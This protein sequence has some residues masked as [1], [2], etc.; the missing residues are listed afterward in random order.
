MR[1][2]TRATLLATI[3]LTTLGAGVSAE[4]SVGVSPTEPTDTTEV[5]DTT[6]V[7]GS[8]EAS[9]STKPVDT[10]DATSETDPADTSDGGPTTTSPVGSDPGDDRG[11]DRDLRYVPAGLEIPETTADDLE[12]VM[13]GEIGRIDMPIVVRNGSDETFQEVDVAGI[14]RDANGTRIAS[15]RSVSIVP[16]VLD[17]GEWGMGVAF[18]STLDV[19][20]DAVIEWVVLATPGTAP[21]GLTMREL[22]VGRPDVRTTG[23]STEIALM[24]T[25][26]KVAETVV[27]SPRAAVGCFDQT[28]R[29]LEVAS[30]F[31]FDDSLAPGESTVLEGSFYGD[32]E[33]ATYAAAAEGYDEF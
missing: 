11:P 14:V 16:S 4:A 8:T 10:P 2:H 27:E 28:G 15:I 24:V 17:P 7:T 23:Y 9:H 1:M 30:A 12:V 32:T 5:S 26:P 21:D 31:G 20:S 19:P 29:L 3:V 25:N 13:H 6:E 18:T 33:C 22:M